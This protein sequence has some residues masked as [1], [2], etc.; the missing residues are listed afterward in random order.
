MNRLIRQVRK[1]DTLL[2]TTN[3]R[4]PLKVFLTFYEHGKLDII[5]RYESAEHL[6]KVLVVTR[7]VFSLSFITLSSAPSFS[8]AGG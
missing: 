2:G 5:L 8:S 3:P 4:K 6:K 1:A 7:E